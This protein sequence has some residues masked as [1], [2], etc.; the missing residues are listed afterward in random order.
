MAAIGNELRDDM[1][2]NY[3]VR[4]PI[5]RAIEPLLGIEEFNAFG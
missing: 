5:R 1:V 4:G 3:V 2:Q